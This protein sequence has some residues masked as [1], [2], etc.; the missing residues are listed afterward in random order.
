VSVDD[1]PA[2]GNPAALPSPVPGVE[3]W[4]CPLERSA[5]EIEQLSGLLSTA[6]LARAARFGTDALR[7]RYVAGRATLRQLLGQRL[8]MPPQ[9]VPIRR[10]ARGRPELEF[11]DAPD[12]NVTHT[13]GVGL[14]AIGETLRIGVDVEHFDRSVAADKLARKFLTP[15]EAETLAPLAPDDRR[16][17]FLRHW[18]C[19]EAM[20]KA[21][22]DGLAAPFGKIEIALGTELVVVGGPPP[23]SPGA[24]RLEAVP[25]PSDFLATIAVWLASGR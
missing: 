7:A 13:R 24:W 16:R 2:A 3:L 9:D 10:G 19:K 5:A 6:E 21:T 12:F 20:S 18:T 11:A 17:Q 14:I 1:L 22:G 25:V 15:R 4:W 8:A 23:Y